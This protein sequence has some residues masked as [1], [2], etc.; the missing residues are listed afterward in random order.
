MAKS[1]LQ[2]LADDLRNTEESLKAAYD[3]FHKLNKKCLSL[4]D[5]LANLEIEMVSSK[6]EIDTLENHK[7]VLVDQAL[8]VLNAG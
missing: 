6:S 1:R 3:N 2:N 4:H 7:A 5:Q 8:G